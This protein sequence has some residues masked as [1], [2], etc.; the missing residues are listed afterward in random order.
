MSSSMIPDAHRVVG[1]L[2]PDDRRR[3]L[4]PRGRGRDDA[5]IE[6]GGDRVA[7][8]YLPGWLP[9]LSAGYVARRQKRPDSKNNRLTEPDKV[10]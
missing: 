8:R 9:V 5:R 3:H 2:G 4:G 7:R 10:M 1:R 6:G